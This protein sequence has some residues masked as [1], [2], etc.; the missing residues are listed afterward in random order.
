MKKSCFR[1]AW[2]LCAL[3]VSLGAAAQT[4]INQA[5]TALPLVAS[6]QF[7]RTPYAAP[8]PDGAGMTHSVASVASYDT[9]FTQI[10]L[11]A[12]SP[13]ADSFPN[14]SHE[15][16]YSPDSLSVFV[17]S[18]QNGIHNVGEHVYTPLATSPKDDPKTMLPFPLQFQTNL[19]DSFHS[20][21]VQP[22]VTQYK[23]GTT[24]F[25]GTGDGSLTTPYGN[26]PAVVKLT[27]VEIS[28]D[29]FVS[30]FGSFASTITTYRQSYFAA[31]NPLPIFE[32]VIKDWGFTAD[33]FSVVMLEF[34]V[35]APEP[36]ASH[37]EIFPNPSHGD[38]VVQMA[39]ATAAAVRFQLIDMQGRILR[40]GDLQPDGNRRAQLHLE[41]LP[42][43]LYH[44]KLQADGNESVQK[45]VIE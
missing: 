23:Y 41:G 17:N 21:N 30:Q 38:V 18:D 11:A 10:R 45:L 9:I 42:S 25:N 16:F 14:A 44:L 39:A 20:V 12:N 40:A 19:L 43:G 15:F 22:T 6:Y 34:L 7:L 3:L 2:F 26:Y 27:S 33:S 31:G 32:S 8:G 28:V 4:V 5:N 24:R 36:Q 37:F 29:S 13:L 1:I 35:A